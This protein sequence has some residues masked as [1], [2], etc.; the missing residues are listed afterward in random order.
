MLG[1]QIAP[2]RASGAAESLGSAAQTAVQLGLILGKPGEPGGPPPPG[3]G[4]PNRTY[5]P[6]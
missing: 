1:S 2:V 6:S 5:E 4:V 3:E